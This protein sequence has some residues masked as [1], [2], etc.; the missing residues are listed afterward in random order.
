[1]TSKKLSSFKYRD[2]VLKKIKSEEEY[3]LVVVGGG[4]TGAGIVRDASM[5]GMKVCLVEKNDFAC[6]TSSRSSKLVHGGLRY[7]ENYEFDLVSEALN[8]RQHLLEIVPHMVKP[9]RFLMPIYKGDRVGM[10]KMGAGMTLYDSLSAIESTNLHELLGAEE[11]N[12]GYEKLKSKGLK[13][14][15]L[16]SDAL[17]DDDRLVYETLRS[18][19]DYDGLSLS[20]AEVVKY[21]NGM[22][23][24]RDHINSNEFIIKTKHVVSAVG[25]WT[26]DFGKI[27]SEKNWTERM[28]PSKGIHITLPKNILNLNSAVVMGADAQKRILFCIPRDGFDIVGTT[29]T[30]YK[31]DASN[32][33]ADQADVKYVLNVL[34]EYYP[35]VE[36]KASDIIST[37][38]GVRPLVNDGSASES[39]VSRDHWVKTD[40]EKAVTYIAGGK[41]TTFLSMA[42]HCVD[43]VINKAFSLS[44][45]VKFR[46]QNTRT[47]F[48]EINIQKNF[49]LAFEKLMNLDLSLSKSERIDFFNTHGPQ[50]LFFVEEFYKEG[51]KLFEL[52]AL[53]AIHYYFCGSIFDFYT[54]R[55][56][57]ILSLKDS[58]ESFL[59]EVK[60]IFKAEL[61]LSE[62]NLLEQTALY[63]ADIQKRR[64]GLN[65]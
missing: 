43:V 64:S 35:D 44:E 5:R 21:E 54:R 4:I 62:E 37:Y 25:P 36:I 32:V 34:K 38:A 40:L 24:V 57:Y 61:N 46:K 58:G 7:L 16:Y 53:V 20:Y 14:G 10:L 41:Y 19:L 23:S 18:A 2:E 55:V 29:D 6:G 26:D 48:V 51:M 17:M 65:F 33:Y 8:E 47:P 11:I 50:S 9:L 28:R 39:K 27:V 13:G 3:D 30:D 31:G 12:E 22:V 63:K 15:F 45:S 59:E 49:D 60:E 42:E 56:S 52:E 1:M